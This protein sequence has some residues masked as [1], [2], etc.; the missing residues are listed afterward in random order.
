MGFMNTTTTAPHGNSSGS[1]DWFLENKLPLL[2]VVIVAGLFCLII[3][4][5]TLYQSV[6]AEMKPPEKP[7]E[8]PSDSSQVPLHVR[9]L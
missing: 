2:V 6:K 8:D 9:D 1:D 4:G 7:Q 5:W 3:L